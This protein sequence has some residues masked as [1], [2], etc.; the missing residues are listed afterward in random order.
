MRLQHYCGTCMIKQALMTM[1]SHA[2]DPQRQIEI[3]NSLV[4]DISGE[5]DQPTPSHFQSILLHKFS[6]YMQ[7]NDVYAGDKKRQNQIASELVPVARE[8]ILHSSHPL[9]T[10][11]LL[12]V[13]GNSIDQLFFSG[14]DLETRIREILN[15]HF[16]IDHFA[17][18]ESVLRNAKRIVFVLDNAGEIYF[19]KLLIEMIQKWK[20]ENRLE[21]AQITCI[22][23][24]GP[25][26]NDATLEDANDARLE[27]VSQ[28]VVNGSNYLG[29]PLDQVNDATKNALWSA[30]L[31]IAKGQANYETLEDNQDFR[32]RIFFFLKSK[33]Q[34]VS[35]HLCVSEGSSVLFSPSC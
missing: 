5:L 8:L 25:I 16:V 9:Y 31:V 24:G 3:L 30:D 22:V 20:V 32:E 10:S 15:H 13:E 7:S 17:G 2:V 27:E 11:A 26:L 21:P 1:N 33:C 35:E 34:H 19:D 14:Y 23:K 28:V 18:F 4:Q 6:N 29:C 12:S